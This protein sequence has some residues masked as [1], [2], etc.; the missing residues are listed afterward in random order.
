MTVDDYKWYISYSF[1]PKQA[2]GS[3]CSLPAATARN[4]AMKKPIVVLHR[5]Q[6]GIDVQKTSC[7]DDSCT[8]PIKAGIE[9]FRTPSTQQHEVHVCSRHGVSPYGS[10]RL[11]EANFQQ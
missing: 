10:Q 9:A 8:Q 3:S 11:L 1:R 2:K 7:K 6:S 4:R 5:F